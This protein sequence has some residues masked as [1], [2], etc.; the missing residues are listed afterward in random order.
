MSGLVGCGIIKEI[1][2]MK[3]QKRDENGLLVGANYKFNDDGSINWRAMIDKKNLYVNKEA[4]QRRGEIPPES[5]DGVKDSDLISNLLGLKEL[6]AMRGYTSVSYRPITA[7]AEYAA[8]VCKIDWI[9]NFETEMKPVS[10]EDCA[11]ANLYNVSEMVQSYL[12]ETATNRAFARTLRNF[13]KISI[14]S[15]EELPPAK[16][17]VAANSSKKSASLMLAELMK[18]KGRTF[19]EMQEKLIAEGVTE[20]QS[21]ADFTDIPGDKAFQLMDRFK[22]LKE[23]RKSK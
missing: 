5:V 15:K 8:V 19:K 22:N 4:F 16:R 20:F 12:L 3:F 2:N 14:V 9:E 18:E 11:C 7:S 13:L 10:F 17:L 23:S 1:K 21:Y 6:A